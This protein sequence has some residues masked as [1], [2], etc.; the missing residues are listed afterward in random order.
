MIMRKIIL[1]FVLATTLIIQSY[2]Q[3]Y[4]AKQNKGKSSSNENNEPQKEEVD[5]PNLANRSHEIGL[6]TGF[7]TGYGLSYRFWPKKIGFQ[8][9]TFPS[10][11]NNEKNLSVGLIGLVELNSKKWYRIFLF[12]GGNLNWTEN[13]NYDSFMS[14]VSPYEFIF[15]LNAPL[16]EIK[17]YTAGFGPGIEFTPG[18]HFGISVMTG[19]RYYYKDYKD[20]S[21]IED[22]WATTVTADIA[23]YYR[24]K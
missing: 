15:N 4:S 20:N 8:F 3:D 1:F 10:I 16:E 17:L 19:F 22:E 21:A 9:T 12:T 13:P 11:T 24:F 2:G 14:D 18:S 7:T 6:A 5:K 23:I